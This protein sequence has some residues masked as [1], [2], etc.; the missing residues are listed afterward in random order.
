MFLP[1][2]QTWYD[3]QGHR[4]FPT[5]LGFSIQIQSCWTRIEYWITQI[6]ALL[7]E[8]WLLK[9]RDGSTFFLGTAFT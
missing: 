7:N 1:L 6:V 2:K 5:C 4:C 8:G 3:A 9:E